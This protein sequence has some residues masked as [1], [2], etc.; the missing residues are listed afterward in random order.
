MQPLER[1]NQGDAIELQA[2]FELGKQKSQRNL[3][4]RAQLLTERGPVSIRLQNISAL[5]GPADL[6]A[7][8]PASGPLELR[9]RFSNLD[10]NPT[11]AGIRVWL[12]RERDEETA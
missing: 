10:V 8:A 2:K 3:R 1:V 7:I 5:G 12:E 11:R 4:L 9:L 6:M